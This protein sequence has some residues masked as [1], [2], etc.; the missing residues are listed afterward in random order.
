MLW[1]PGTRSTSA[2]HI[3]GQGFAVHQCNYAGV[4]SSCRV[5]RSGRIYLSALNHHRPVAAEYGCVAWNGR[6]DEQQRVEG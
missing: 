2:H 3:L 5:L 6:S 4:K 1:L